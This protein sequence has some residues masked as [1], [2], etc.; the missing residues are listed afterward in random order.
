MEAR[1]IHISIEQ[2]LDRLFD[3]LSGTGP[4]GRRVLIEA[5]AHLAESTDVLER[6]GRNPDDAAREAL[7]R[8]GSPDSIAQAAMREDSLSVRLVLRRGLAAAWLLGSVALASF[9]LAGVLNFA[10]GTLFGPGW[11][12]PDAPHQTYPAAR[13]A[14]LL[15][16]YPDGTSC[17][18]ASVAHHFGELVYLPLMLSVLGFVLLALFAIA[19]RDVRL[20]R[21]AMLPPFGLVTLLGTMAFGSGAAILVI[22][23]L[24]RLQIGQNFGIG[25]PLAHA[26]ALTVAALVLLPSAWRELRRRVLA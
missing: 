7:A 1:M 11:V 8:F 20:R 22:L 23:A 25:A 10:F 17:Q 2:Y 24:Q 6:E 14:R 3:A 26:A 16:A 9:G 19:R 4:H 18:A 5:E 21:F 13:C 15:A 12:A